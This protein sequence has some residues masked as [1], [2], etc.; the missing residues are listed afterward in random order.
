VRKLAEVGFVLLRKEGTATL[1]SINASCC[2]GLR[3]PRTP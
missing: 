1:V 3:T 2:T